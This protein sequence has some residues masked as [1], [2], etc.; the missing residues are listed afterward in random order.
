M[1]IKSSLALDSAVA[2]SKVVVIAALA[3]CLPLSGWSQLVAELKMTQY[4][5]LFTSD[6]AFKKK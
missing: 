2:R 6:I 3:T 5:V 1:G 4:C